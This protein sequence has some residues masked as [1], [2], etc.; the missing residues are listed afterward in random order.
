MREHRKKY[1]I[2]NNI[3]MGK[4]IKI[5]SRILG[6][7]ILLISCYFLLALFD[8]IID[9]E[10]TLAGGYWVGLVLCLSGLAISVLLIL[11]P[12]RKKRL[13]KTE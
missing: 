5:I 11:S 9:G 8:D 7:I 13:S 6:I 1:I 10:A 12:K 4:I 3:S 2:L